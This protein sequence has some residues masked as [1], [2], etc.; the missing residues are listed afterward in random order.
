[1][2]QMNLKIKK[3]VH[4]EEAP[5]QKMKKELGRVEDYINII[6][7]HE[8]Y[9]TYCFSIPASYMDSLLYEALDEMTTKFQACY[10]RHGAVFDSDEE[11]QRFDNYEKLLDCA[12]FGYEEPNGKARWE[13]FEVKESKIRTRPGVT[14][15]IRASNGIEW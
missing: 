2:A 15:F 1:M 11:K 14:H 5:E 9:N 7:L 10:V 12:L 8:G 6:L 13:E 3:D 4:G